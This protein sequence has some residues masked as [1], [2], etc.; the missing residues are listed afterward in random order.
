MF[1]IVDGGMPI[2]AL[3]KVDESILFLYTYVVHISF[4]HEILFNMPIRLR[5][6][7]RA[8]QLSSMGK[9]QKE[10]SHI[11]LPFSFLFSPFLNFNFF[12]SLIVLVIFFPL[13]WH[14]EIFW[15]FDYAKY[16]QGFGFY[17]G[18]FL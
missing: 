8:L 3:S 9:I 14:L 18:F 17:M 1:S 6:A 16:H 4:M 13:S 2:A 12:T 7:K 11:F 10:K 5:W 15:L